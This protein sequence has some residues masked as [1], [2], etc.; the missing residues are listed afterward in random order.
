MKQ[1]EQLTRQ[2]F[3]GY[4]GKMMA[5]Y[6]MNFMGSI[7]D[8]IVISRFLG[9]D[10]MAAF[11]LV[12]PLILLCTM[13]GMMFST[14]LQTVCSKCLGSG[15]LEDAKRFYTVTMIGLAPIALLF[16]LGVYFF[17]EPL[18]AF[19]GATG[20]SAYLA[21]EATDYLKGVAMSLG[22]VVFMPSLTII[23]FLEGNSK[24]SMISIACQL[25]I[26]VAG[27]FFN[28]FYL[29]WGLLGMGL[30][31][32]LC[33]LV[34]FCVM[35]YGKLRTKG[36]ISFTRTG[37]AFSKFANVLKVGLPSA[38]DRLYRTLQTFVVNNVLLVV[39]TGTSVAAYGV[40]S[41]VNNIFTPLVMG[42]TA[43]GLTM[44][45]IFYGEKDKEGLQ[46]LFGM[47]MKSSVLLSV[48]VAV[49]VT[50]AAPLLVLLFK[51]SADPSF[52]PAVR[53]VR[54]FIW[55]YPFYGVNKMLQDYYLGCNTPKM[56]YL[57]STLESL[58]FTILA[59]VVLGKLFGEDGVWFG[60]VVGEALAVIVTLMVIAIKKKRI[61]RRAE[62]MLFL[63]EEFD[64]VKHCDWS[65]TNMDEMKEASIEAKAFMLEHG[66]EAD[67][68]ALVGQFL[69]D[70]GEVLVLWGVEDSER[71]H[72]DIRLVCNPDNSQLTTHN[73]S[74]LSTLNSQLSWTIRVRDD[75]KQFDLQKWQA[76]H[77]EE[78]EKHVSIRTMDK[79]SKESSFAYTM[80][81]NYL[82]VT[83]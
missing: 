2:T 23:L 78:E 29:H 81:L 3:R 77:S 50:F 41:S 61:P 31:T 57:V 34:G 11:Q 56:T 36:G 6:L 30:S 44:A 46:G 48:G 28:A 10:F 37:L 70:L 63:P 32:S 59:V 65:A 54:I 17:A 82:F 13:L 58:V 25:V 83:I 80:G 39:A 69:V 49:V 62:D 75:R 26:N 79:M 7:I 1:N 64:T 5:N 53:A 38:L 43:T 47:T 21:S 8:G 51:S 18:V 74:K 40:L 68:A 15:S 55:T 22:L 12:M 42:I 52:A 71:F 4:S 20:D 24:H 19:L 66:A 14:G 27:D 45:G 73:N 16:A 76:V 9:T 67:K 60:F 35:M 72:A 33:T